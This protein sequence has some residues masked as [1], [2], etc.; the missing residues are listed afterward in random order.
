MKYGVTGVW[1]DDNG[2]ITHYAIH[3][4]KSDTMY[5][6]TKHSKS[7]AVALIEKST[8]TA[9]TILWNYNDA[10]WSLGEDVEVVNGVKEKYLRSNP[11][12]KETN[13]LAHL[14]DFAI[15]PI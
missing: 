3:E 2:V 1:K 6:A 5:G 7:K 14:I 9:I 4:I 10:I 13:N 12:K 15:I 8:N 11:D